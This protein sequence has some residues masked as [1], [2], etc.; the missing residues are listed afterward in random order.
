MLFLVMLIC[1][2]FCSKEHQDT[3]TLENIDEALGKRES[4]YGILEHYKKLL[5]QASS[6]EEFIREHVYRLRFGVAG[7]AL[8]GLIHLGYAH[9]FGCSQ[10]ML[11]GMA[12]IHHSHCP[13]TVTE[14]KW[15]P[16]G[17]G[18]LNIVEIINLVREDEQL[19]NIMIDGSTSEFWVSKGIGRFQS[20]VGP[21]LVSAG[22]RLAEYVNKL[23]YDSPVTDM[24]SAMLLARWLVDSTLAVYSQSEK[25]N[26]F[27]LLHGVTGAWS[28][29]QALS[30]FD[31]YER[32][33]EMVRIYI[34]IVFAVYLAR[35]SP[36][37]TVQLDITNPNDT[38]FWQRTI[39]QTVGEDR[40]EHIYKLVQVAHD[41]YNDSTNDQQRAVCMAA[42]KSSLANDLL[43]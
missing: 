18:K 40:D 17:S 2:S 43:I 13:L 10:S 3:S 28:L 1:Y 7:S 33:V 26:D 21:L 23:Q 4:Y 42:A 25:R 11:E 38:D 32:A 14:D 29:M 19:K 8:H 20:K 24:R 36:A 12:Y 22:D 16:F 37:L 39:A 34:C 5:G 9:S 31:D 15:Q 6:K 41:M 27:F 30:C 35:D